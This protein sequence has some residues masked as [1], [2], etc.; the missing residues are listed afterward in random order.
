MCLK[1]LKCSQQ[2]SWQTKQNNNWTQYLQTIKRAAS[3]TW[4]L[5]YWCSQTIIFKRLIVFHGLRVKQNKNNRSQNLHNCEGRNVT[6]AKK[7]QTTYQPSFFTTYLAPV[8]GNCA[9]FAPTRLFS[10]PGYPMLSFKFVPW[11]PL[12]PW[13]LTVLIQRRNW[14]QQTLLHHT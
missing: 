1:C 4:T 11:R 14:L 13:Q 8:K 2:V 10:G 5:N 7:I 6:Y 12:L 3:K 9:L